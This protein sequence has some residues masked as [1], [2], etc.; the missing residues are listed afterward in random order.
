MRVGARASGPKSA[1]PDTRL[2]VRCRKASLL[3]WARDIMETK[4]KRE[5]YLCL[6]NKLAK[7][8]GKSF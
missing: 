1:G 6:L 4:K 7:P 5:D 8:L 3:R 2:R